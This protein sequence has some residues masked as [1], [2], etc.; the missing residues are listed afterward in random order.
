MTTTRALDDRR[1]AWR[2][3]QCSVCGQPE[4]EGC[5]PEC[6]EGGMVYDPE[7]DEQIANM[8]IE[9]W[10]RRLLPRS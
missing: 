4:S 5:F 2:E 9:R 1:F 3:G 10:I 7:R 6:D 8:A